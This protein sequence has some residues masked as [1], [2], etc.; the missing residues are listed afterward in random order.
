[1]DWNALVIDIFRVCL[2]PLFGIITAYLTNF[3]KAKKAEIEDKVENEKLATYLQ[4]LDDT[5]INCVISTNQTYVE[6]LKQSGTFNLEA[7]KEAFKLTYEAVIA[8]I[9]KD[10]EAYLA[11]A[12]GDL[13]TYITNKIEAEVSLN[14]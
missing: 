2:I 8:I 6:S 10:A 3:L 13:Y 1:M 14:K 7:Q 5:I 9:G 4:M 11:L 12:L